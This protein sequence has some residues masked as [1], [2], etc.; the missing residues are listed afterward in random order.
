MAV[1]LPLSPV[2]V[3]SH[4]PDM[5]LP[6]TV[7]ER[8]S[9]SPVEKWSVREIELPLID[10]ETLP[11]SPSSEK[12]PLIDVPFWLRCMDPCIVSPGMGFV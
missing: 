12:D 8:R 1:K 7:P 3:S 5:L 4:D 11:L 10:P 2:S 9:T 6:L